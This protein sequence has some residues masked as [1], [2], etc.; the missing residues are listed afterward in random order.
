M[1][2]LWH[3]ESTFTIK[4]KKTTLAIDPVDGG[5]HKLDSSK[6]D[7]VCMTNDYHEN[8]KLV[9][10]LE[11]ADIIN[12]PGEYEIKGAA[13]VAIPAFTNEQ[14]EGDTDTGRIVL[15]SMLLDDVRI[16]HLAEIGQ[17]FDE[18]ILSKIGGV[19]ILFVSAASTKGL[20]I[21]KLH[22]AIEDIDPRV[23]IPMNYKDENDL[24]PFLKELGVTEHETLDVFEIKDKNQLPD[25]K[26]DFIVL[27]AV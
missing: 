10:G 17:D 3:G 15:F 6:A 25:D 26:T 18:E 24:D 11:D 8:A 5:K 19:D 16:C 20:S 2:I 7:T 1:E 12:W 9:K 21:K 4:G 13:I 27:K 23:I 22:R 14:K